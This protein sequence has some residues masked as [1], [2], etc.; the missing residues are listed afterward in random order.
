MVDVAHDRDHG[1]PWHL[2]GSDLGLF[3]ILY[4]LFLVGD[5]IG[6]G[7]ELA[8]KLFRKLGVERLVDGG[9]DLPL[10]QL[11]MS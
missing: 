6:L 2:V 1:R 3:D 5:F 9:E 10:D 8:G 11:L 7:S 4:G